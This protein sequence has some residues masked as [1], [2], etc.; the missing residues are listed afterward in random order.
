LL[1]NVGQNEGK[2]KGISIYTLDV[3][4][5]L[6]G[7]LGLFYEVKEGKPQHHGVGTGAHG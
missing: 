6:G 7:Y 3:F 4:L 1:A 2:K 5:F